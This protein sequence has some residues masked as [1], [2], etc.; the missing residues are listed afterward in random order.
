VR[1]AW[2]NV[3]SKYQYTGQFSY[4]QEFGL[5]FY[6]ARWYDSAL[7]RFAQA[8]TII[9]EQTQGVQAW[10]RYAYVSNNPTRYNDP[11]GHCPTCIGALI[12]GAAGAILYIV[13]E[14]Q[15]A[16]GF[17]FKNDWKD[18]A[19]ATGTG[20]LAGALIATP[21]G[22]ALGIG[23]ASGLIADHATNIITSEDFSVAGN[24]EAG[25]VGLMVGTAS[26]GMGSLVLEG[27]TA[28][29]VM[30]MKG[31]AASGIYGAYEFLKR[32][33]G[34]VED[35]DPIGD[36]VDMLTVGI[37]EGVGTGVSQSLKPIVGDTVSEA[38]GGLASASLETIVNT[39]THRHRGVF[40]R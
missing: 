31:L 14:S 4:E 1:Y 29:E 11:S 8:D 20:A 16:D 25:A 36:T 26:L 40:E 15:Q 35:N 23:M 7:S 24:V 37:G 34:M 39:F 12:G 10:D 28:M 22:T 18:L 3:P 5:Y 38:A 30:M 6:N 21:G 17:D 2:G 19:V 27:A 13:S 9:P 33:T 32:R